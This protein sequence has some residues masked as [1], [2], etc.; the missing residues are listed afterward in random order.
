MKY[1]VVYH[2][3]FEID[4]FEK[5]VNKLIKKGWEPHGNPFIEDGNIFQAMIKYDANQ[6]FDY[7][8]PY[9]G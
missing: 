2:P 7:V 9:I 6:N 8:R 5:S 4:V 1:K 3:S